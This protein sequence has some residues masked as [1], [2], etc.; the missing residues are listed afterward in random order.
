M[1]SIL[2]CASVAL[3]FLHKIS[4]YQEKT[5]A[6]RKERVIFC[7]FRNR[8][9]FYRGRRNFGKKR[10]TERLNLLADTFSLSQ[11]ISD[12]HRVSLL[13]LLV[14]LCEFSLALP[15]INTTVAIETDLFHEEGVVTSR[16]SLYLPKGKWHLVE[17]VGLLFPFLRKTT[18]R[19]GRG[20]SANR[21]IECF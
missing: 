18:C 17:E 14:F 12:H 19:P 7:S 2:L 4:R 1:S 15:F 6:R 16:L 10:R 21:S 11:L 9:F 20:I 8:P 13:N 3:F 5:W